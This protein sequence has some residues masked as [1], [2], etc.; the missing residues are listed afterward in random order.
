MNKLAS[1]YANALFDLA[2]EEK[3]DEVLLKE[4]KIIQDLFEKNPGLIPLFAQSQISKE[5]KKEL[6]DQAFGWAHPYVVNTLKLLIDKHR[7]LIVIDFCKGF[8]NL[9][10]ESHNIIQGIAYTVFALSDEEL[11]ALE[12]DISEKEKCSIELVN[13]IDPTLLKGIKIRYGDKVIDASLKAR[14]EALRD[15]LIEGRS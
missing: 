4:I 11:R 9:Y 6:I 5:A 1:R 2:T 10:N 3:I 14:I 7:A 12:N 15:N 13:R 8:R